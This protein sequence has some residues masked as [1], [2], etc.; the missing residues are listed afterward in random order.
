[1]TVHRWSGMLLG[2]AP[3]RISS[4][5]SA[6]WSATSAQRARGVQPGAAL[7][8]AGDRR[9]LDAPAGTFDYLDRHCR[10][11]REDR[12]PFG[13]IQVIG[14]GDFLQLPPVRTESTR[15]L[16]LGLRRAGMGGGGIPHRRADARSCARTTR[17]SWLA[18]AKFRRGDIDRDTERLL[19]AAG[20]HLPGRATSPGS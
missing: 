1:M 5:T 6:S 17:N 11:I 13:G 15:A 18:L 19:R 10:L 14:T 7:P 12:R 3:G 9:N 16:R 20:H 2:P 4:A 8:T